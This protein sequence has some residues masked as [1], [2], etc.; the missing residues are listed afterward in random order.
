M[1]NF[2]QIKVNNDV[3]GSTRSA[4]KNLSSFCV[5]RR[6]AFCAV[7]GEEKARYERGMGIGGKGRRVVEATKIKTAGDFEGGL[8]ISKNHG[9]TGTR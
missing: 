9:A 6:S 7:L 2:D 5:R 3:A 1:F 8:G 4:D